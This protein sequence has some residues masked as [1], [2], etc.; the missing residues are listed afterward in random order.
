VLP[1]ELLRLPAELAGVDLLD[2]EAFFAPFRARP[3]AG[4][5]GRIRGTAVA[6]P[7]VYWQLCQSTPAAVRRNPGVSDTPRAFLPT[8]AAAEVRAGRRQGHEERPDGGCRIHADLTAP[9]HP[10]DY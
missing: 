7:A 9:R 4:G 2:D 1:E 10:M 8:A 3:F 6:L 5:P